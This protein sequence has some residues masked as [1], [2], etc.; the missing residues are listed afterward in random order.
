MFEGGR[1]LGLSVVG[2]LVV[3][4]VVTSKSEK[5]SV[6]LVVGHD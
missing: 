3:R 6:K 5:L 4:A 1:G 2:S